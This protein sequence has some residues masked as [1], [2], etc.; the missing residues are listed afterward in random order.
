[1]SIALT[2]AYQIVFG[3]YATDMKEV[4]AAY[5]RGKVSSLFTLGKVPCKSSGAFSLNVKTRHFFLKPLN[6]Q[7]E[8]NVAEKSRFWYQRY[9]R[10]PQFLGISKHAKDVF[11]FHF[12]KAAFKWTNFLVGALWIND[13]DCYSF[14]IFRKTIFSLRLDPFLKFWSKWWCEL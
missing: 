2:E 7:N 4:R 13:A 1:M 14:F 5:E 10:T 6:K 8:R 9:R 3:F 12:D 11:R